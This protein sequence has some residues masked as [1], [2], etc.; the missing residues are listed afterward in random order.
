MKAI[1]L[2]IFSLSLFANPALL[3][4]LENRRELVKS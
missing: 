4:R 3:E 1:L 2:S